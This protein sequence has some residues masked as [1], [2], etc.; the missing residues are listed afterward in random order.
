MMIVPGRVFKSYYASKNEAA[1]YLHWR[2]ELA[3][4]MK[5]KHYCFE[6]EEVSGSDMEK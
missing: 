1:P 4:M 3:G 2:P 5:S 6:K